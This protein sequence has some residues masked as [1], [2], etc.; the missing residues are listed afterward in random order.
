MSMKYYILHFWPLELH[1]IGHK[2]KFN[3][4]RICLNC[5]VTEYLDILCRFFNR[6]FISVLP[7]ES[8]L[9]RELGYH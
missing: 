2:A 3:F 9:S 4:P 6:R 1:D 7:M 8:Q 5:P